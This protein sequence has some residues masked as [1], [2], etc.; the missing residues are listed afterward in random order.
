MKPEQ[1][2]EKV[3]A[4][5]APNVDIL[6]THTPVYCR[7]DKTSGGVHVGSQALVS[8]L[9]RW[10]VA[11]EYVICGHIHEGRGQSTDR[12]RKTTYLNVAYVD[13]LYKPY[14]KEIPLLAL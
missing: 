7:C 5:I 11:P 4:Q 10:I 6:V 13:G 9:E 3:Y 8:E 12:L 1:E 2:L 14:Q